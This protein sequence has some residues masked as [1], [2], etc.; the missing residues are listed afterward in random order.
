MSFSAK[1]HVRINKSVEVVFNAVVEPEKLCHYFTSYASAPMTEGS[2]LTWGWA[3]AG[4]ESTVYVEKVDLNSRII[5]QWPATGTN[6]TVE[7]QFESL[8]DGGT[9]VSA[10]ETGNWGFDLISV[11]QACGQTG[12]WMHF[13]LCLKAY[14]EYGI[15]L[16]EGAVCK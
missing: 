16:R 6:R 8:S 4:A 15:H 5:F 10:E 3:D 11:E 1:A 14:L 9:R 12:G 13:F 2:T 7:L